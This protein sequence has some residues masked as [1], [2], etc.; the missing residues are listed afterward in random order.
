MFT[1][2]PGG[3]Y[4]SDYP[5]GKENLDIASKQTFLKFRSTKHFVKTIILGEIPVRVL[6]RKNSNLS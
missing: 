4:V 5:S 1:I 6:T 3:Y 2:L